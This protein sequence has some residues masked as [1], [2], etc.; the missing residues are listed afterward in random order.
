MKT[1]E[2]RGRGWW[3][4]SLC[5]LVAATAFGMGTFWA[6]VVTQALNPPVPALYDDPFMSAINLPVLWSCCYIAP[7]ALLLVVGLRT[8]FLMLPPRFQLA[9]ACLL[10]LGDAYCVTT[11]GLNVARLASGMEHAERLDEPIVTLHVV[12]GFG[13]PIS[14][15]FATPD[16]NVFGQGYSADKNG[17][18]RLTA[19]TG[20][21][22]LVFA[23][24]FDE[25]RILSSVWET[26][27]FPVV[28]LAWQ[29]ADAATNPVPVHAG[30]GSTH[31]R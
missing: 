15:A 17:V 3:L 2:A 25:Q 23:L 22:I 11:Y 26:N 29:Q 12:D 9:I 7:V 30:G 24:H 18:I 21:D 20:R 16:V 31:A 6:R 8:K 1:G 27:R 28:K 13:R 5:L 19:V 4:A 14:T 10:L